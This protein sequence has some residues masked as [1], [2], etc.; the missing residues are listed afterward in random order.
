[1]KNVCLIACAS[2]KQAAAAPAQ[3][4]YESELFRK[5]VGWMHRQNFDRWFILSAKHG[6]VKPEQ[7]LEPYNLTLNTIKTHARRQWG[8][9]VLDELMSVLPESASITFLAGSK[10]REYLSEPLREKGNEILIPMQGLGIGKQLQW[11]DAH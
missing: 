8:K 11:L 1:M 2:Q 9:I 4:L 5:S 6:L 7:I 10:Y 3:D